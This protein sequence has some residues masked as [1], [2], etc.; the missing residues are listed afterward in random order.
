MVAEKEP[1]LRAIVLLAGI[2]QPGRTALHFQLKNGIERNT[3]LTPEMRASQ[4]AE[5][6]KKIDALMAADP[7]MKFFLTYDPASTMRRVKIPVLILTGSRDQQAVPEEV[8]LM[9][10][11]FKEGGNKDV[12]ARVLPNLNHLFVYDTDGFPGNYAKLP[13]PVTV[14]TDVLELVADWLS[15]RLR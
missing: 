13:A 6:D 2:A 8:A 3:K 4:I 9:E 14:Q 12:T 7:W 5:I 1:T 10:A 11:A 15:R